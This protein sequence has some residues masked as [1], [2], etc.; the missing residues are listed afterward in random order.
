MSAT[1]FVNFLSRFG[2]KSTNVLPPEN[3]E[4]LFIPENTRP[5]LYWLCNA[6][7]QD[8]ILSE[9]ELQQYD[10]LI[11]AQSVL[12]NDALSSA[13]ANTP[14]PPPADDDTPDELLLLGARLRQLTARRDMFFSLKAEHQQRRQQLLS[15]QQA[16][17]R[18]AAEAQAAAERCGA[19]LAAAAD[20]L[21]AETGRLYMLY[22]SIMPPD[23]DDTTE[24][25]QPPRASRPIEGLLLATADVAPYEQA[26]TVFT[27]AIR[28]FV[29]QMREQQPAAIAAE[30]SVAG[31][32][33]SASDT[34]APAASASSRADAIVQQILFGG[35]G[36]LGMRSDLAGRTPTG[37]VAGDVPGGDPVLARQSEELARLQALYPITQV[38]LLEASARAAAWESIG[39]SVALDTA[40]TAAAAEAANDRDTYA[41]GAAPAARSALT[42]GEWRLLEGLFEA[43]EGHA[44]ASAR[45]EAALEPDLWLPDDD[46]TSGNGDGN[47]GAEGGQ[48][49]SHPTAA[50]A[51][52]ASSSAEGASCADRLRA[53]AEALT[54]IF[55][56]SLHSMLERL[57]RVQG[58]EIVQH[59][60]RA[61]HQH[62]LRCAPKS[63]LLLLHT[64]SV[65]WAILP[66]ALLACAR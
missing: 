61:R 45:V 27:R 4:W 53:A 29:E 18:S 65:L 39:T 31:G 11:A 66:L 2:F 40:T 28:V 19:S 51:L 5:F 50:A 14:Q 64:I 10:K 36:S 38:Q 42:P 33:H 43:P 20:S 12:H 60:Y 56:R 24:E 49:S 3:F 1:E 23:D 37:T 44:F 52:P 9:D 34:P 26:D 6:F 55:G 41:S 21:R 15:Q 46:G 22:E 59:S 35:E 57:A 48:H 32:Q 30:S 63:N 62:H 58:A 8:N 16:A 17:E 13:L 54:E 47:G 25:I 7:T